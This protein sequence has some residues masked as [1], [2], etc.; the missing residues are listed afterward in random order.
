MKTIVAHV[1]VDLDAISSAWLIRRFRPGWENTQ[2]KFVPAGKTLDGKPPDEDPNIAHVDT[3]LGMFDHHQLEDRNTCGARRVFDYLVKNKHIKPHDVEPLTRIVDFVV[4]IDNFKE[5][6]F[7]D[8]TSDIYDFA[9][10]QLLEGLKG[11][12]THDE[13][14]CEMGFTLLDGV[15]QLFRNKVRAEKE[16][17]EGLIFKS[18]WGRSLALETRNEEAMRLALLSGFDF[19]VRKDAERGYVRVKTKPG[20]DLDLTPLSE[21]LKEADPEATWFLHSSKN[22]L[23]NGTSKNPDMKPSRL[24]LQKVV[25]I[26]KK[27]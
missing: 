2:L 21:K 8:P 9:L 10:H 5:V 16:I 3:G 22:M 14:R 25:E 1:S 12:I 11:V 17:K 6:F 4:T 15:L 7:H 19:V 18:H 27:I 23:L 13:E 24:P 26:I 20:P